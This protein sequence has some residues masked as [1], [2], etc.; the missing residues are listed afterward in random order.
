MAWISKR[1]VVADVDQYALQRNLNTEKKISFVIWEK[2]NERNVGKA[3]C[4]GGHFHT[5]GE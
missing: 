5:A 1:H 3:H 2:K 4:G